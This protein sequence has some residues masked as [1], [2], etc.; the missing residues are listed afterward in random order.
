MPIWTYSLDW[1]IIAFCSFYSKSFFKMVPRND[2]LINDKSSVT[3]IFVSRFIINLIFGKH[4]RTNANALFKCAMQLTTTSGFDF[5]M[6]VNSLEC[7]PTRGSLRTTF[8]HRHRKFCLLFLIAYDNERR[9]KVC[10][11]NIFSN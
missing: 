7:L 1:Q 6:N 8:S 9:I 11:I 2:F 3:L 10:V 4:N 5:K